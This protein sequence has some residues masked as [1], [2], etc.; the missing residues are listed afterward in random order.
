MQATIQKL[1]E[2]EATLRATGNSAAAAS[3][4]EQA[5]ALENAAQRHAASCPPS[6]PATYWLGL[7]TRYAELQ[8]ANCFERGTAYYGLICPKHRGSLSDEE[9]EKFCQEALAKLK[10]LA[11]NYDK[12]WFA[13]EM[14]RS[15]PSCD[16]EMAAR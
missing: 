7:G 12:Q 4:A 11:A 5:Q 6:G 9:W 10:P 1:R 15:D 13:D 16:V 3:A 2:A 8:N 14:N